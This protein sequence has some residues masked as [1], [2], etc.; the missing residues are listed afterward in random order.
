MLKLVMIVFYPFLWVWNEISEQIRE[1][2][3]E[4]AKCKREDDN[5]FTQWVDE[6]KTSDNWSPIFR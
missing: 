4:R 6:K 3:L 2:K 1:Y 5:M